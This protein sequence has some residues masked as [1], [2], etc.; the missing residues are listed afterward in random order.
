MSGGLAIFVKTPG[1]SPVKTRL[2]ADCGRAYAEDWYRHAAAA[3]VSVVR[4]A[5][6]AHGI[7]PYWAV[8]EPDAIANGAWQGLPVLD[9]GE[10]GLGERMARVHASLVA[11]HGAGVLIGA[12]TPQLSADLLG[13]AIAWL[14]QPGP[15]LSLGPARDGGFWLFGGNVA[16]PTDAWLQVRYSERETARELRRAMKDCGQWQTLPELTDL[17]H[18]NDLAEVY[19]A[20]RRLPEPRQEQLQLIEWMYSSF[21]PGRDS[22]QPDGWSFSGFEPSKAKTLVEQPFG[23]NP[24]VP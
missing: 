18:G 17:D 16:P 2:A 8:A 10:G 3:V 4:V 23:C 5:A 22:Q 7:E 20:L 9:Q 19:D 21:P 13:T 15:R 12:D 1:Y 24:K 11:R 14:Q 6:T